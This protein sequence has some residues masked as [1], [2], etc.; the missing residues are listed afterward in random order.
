MPSGRSIARSALAVGIALVASSVA[1]EARADAA[2]WFHSGGGVL[3]FKDAPDADLELAPSLTF[4]LG[5]GTS[6]QKDFIFGGY[7]RVMPLLGQGADLALMTRF[8]NQGFQK[9]WIG[10]A[11]DLG[12]Y[13]RF[14][15]VGSTGFTGQA[16]LGGPFGL[17]LAALG[18]VGSNSNWGVGGT[19]GID[20][21]RLVVEREH[22]LDWWPNPRPS[23]AMYET[24]TLTR[25]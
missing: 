12:A 21:V 10:F 11:I 9:G 22:L 23:D 2:A 3:A 14:W 18:M 15:G 13:Q 19:L 4:D 6:T 20:L 1:D 8:A 25:W 7:F 24:A 16:V 17:Q 5:L